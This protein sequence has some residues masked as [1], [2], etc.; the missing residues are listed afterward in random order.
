[1]PVAA[2]LAVVT[3]CCLLNLSAA[4][5]DAPA[6]TRL[7]RPADR[8]IELSDE[9]V[10]DVLTPFQVAMETHNLDHLLDTFD[11]EAT[12]DFPRI[13]DQ[14]RAFFR[15]TDTIKFRYQILQ[16]S[17]DHDSAIATA[18][19]DMDALPADSLPTE[20]RRSTQMRFQMKRTPKGWRLTALKP[21]DFFTQ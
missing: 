12:P 15:L 20:Q 2:V 14:F 3:F 1:M 13:R 11:S 6:D 9:L 8:P 7:L 16:A 18:D 17:A 5:Q 10:H 19:V 4:A 21:M